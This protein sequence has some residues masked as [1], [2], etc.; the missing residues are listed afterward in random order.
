MRVEVTPEAQ[1]GG[2]EVCNRTGMTKV[3]MHSRLIEW[4]ARQDGDVLAVVLGQVSPELLPD[5]VEKFLKRMA[6]K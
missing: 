1:S 3:A 4:A 5:P 6:R 2:D